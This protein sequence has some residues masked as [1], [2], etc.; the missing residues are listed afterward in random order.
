[1][2]RRLTLLR[3]SSKL[4]DSSAR[5]LMPE[6]IKIKLPDGSEKEFPKGATAHDVAMSISPRLASAALAAQVKPSS[7]GGGAQSGADKNGARLVDLKRP[8]EKDSELRIL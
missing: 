6:T 2:K 8:I 3:A 4:K 7:N 5:L 1:M